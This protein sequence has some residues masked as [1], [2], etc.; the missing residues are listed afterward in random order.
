VSITPEIVDPSYIFVKPTIQAYFNREIGA[1]SATVIESAIRTSVLEFSRI[2]LEQFNSYFKYSKF[3]RTIDSSAPSIENSSL[4]IK[5]ATKIAINPN[6]SKSISA[7]FSNA[8]FYPHVGHFG[9]IKTSGFTYFGEPNCYLSDDGA[10]TINIYRDIIGERR[11]VDTNKGLVNYDTGVFSATFTPEGATDEELEVEIH[12][13]NQD[14]FSV[15]NQILE[16][17]EGDILVTAVDAQTRYVGA[18]NLAVGETINTGVS[19][20]GTTSSSS[21]SSSSSGY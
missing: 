1:A 4:S 12:P 20:S 10:G 11:L 18:T 9:S 6:K 16:I 14:I 13:R 5:L 19:Y 15:R 21:S 3:L 17:L 2:D 8:I 7:S